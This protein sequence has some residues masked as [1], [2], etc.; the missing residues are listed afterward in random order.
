MRWSGVERRTSRAG[1]M[2]GPSS[3]SGI[4]EA[5]RA[6]AGANTSRPWNVRETGCSMM[7]GF[8]IATASTTPP[9]ASAAGISRPL[10][11]P[12]KWRPSPDRSATAR[13]SEPTPGSTTARC[14][15][16]GR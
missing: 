4:P 10:S 1:S 9:Q 5:S 3:E 6:A 13:R 12:T 14:T 2:A 16:T 11:G 15:P 8:V 7:S